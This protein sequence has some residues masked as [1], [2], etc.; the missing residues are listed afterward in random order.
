MT[1]AE[2]RRAADL[3]D[4]WRAEAELARRLGA[5]PQA[6]VLEKCA[7]DFEAAEC[8]EGKE[9]L[10]LTQAALRSGFSADALGRMLRDGRLTNHG[11]KNA[12][13]VR[14]CDLPRKALR[15][16]ALRLHIL[17]ASR[18]KARVSPKTPGGS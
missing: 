7:A 18:Q 8:A 1:G 16:P 14:V 10:N 3:P 5:E 6:V 4:R 15:P 17:D 12:P 13:R 11:R 9:L 2:L